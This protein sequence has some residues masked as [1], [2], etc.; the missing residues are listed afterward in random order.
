MK[1]PPITYNLLKEKNACQDQ[2]DL[3]KQHIGLIEPIPLTTETIQKFSQDFDIDWAADHLLDAVDRKEYHKAK[4]TAWA[5]L[6]K[7]TK[8]ALA[9]YDKAIAPALAEYDKA[10]APALAEL[11]KAIA[12]VRA[13][14]EKARTTAWAEYNKAKATE[15]VRLYKQDLTS[16]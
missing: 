2:L 8:P 9:E 12:P 5:E 7:A 11:E 4:D 16:N 10:I 3:F 15:F 6:E 14:Y 13:E 1:Y